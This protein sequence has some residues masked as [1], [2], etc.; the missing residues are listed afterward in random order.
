[1][2][3]I[4]AFMCVHTLFPLKFPPQIFWVGLLS[5][6]MHAQPDHVL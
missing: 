1:M 5:S 4:I 6:M 2:E 3:I